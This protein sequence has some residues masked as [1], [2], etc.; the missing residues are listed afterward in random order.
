M[1]NTQEIVIDQPRREMVL[2]DNHRGNPPNH[3]INN[4]ANAQKQ[5]P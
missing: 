2:I 4:I 1:K 5:R 3:L